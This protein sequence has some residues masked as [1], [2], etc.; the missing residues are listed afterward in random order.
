MSPL[1]RLRIETVRT[2]R[3]R[4]D[5]YRVRREIYRSDPAAVIP[6]RKMEWSFLN[7]SV[8]PFY[9]HARREVFLAYEGNRP[10]GRIAAIVDDLHNQHYADRLGFF[11]FFECPPDQEVADRLLNAA[12][13]YLVSQGRDQVRGPMNPSMKGEFGVLVEGHQHPPRVMMAHTTN[14]YAQL[15]ETFGF[16][17]V[18]RFHAYSLDVANDPDWGNKV[19]RMRALSDRICARFPDLKVEPATKANVE[20]RLYEINTIGNHIRSVGWGFVPLTSEE[21]TYMVNQLRRVI[22][23]RAVVTAHYKNELVGYV[24]TVPD[25]N[26]AIK[27]TKGPYDW[28]R[29]AQMPRLLKKIRQCR[30]IAI[31]VH[32]DFRRKGINTVLTKKMFDITNDYDHWEFGWIAED[33]T[34]S[35]GALSSAVPLDRY[36]VYHVYQRAL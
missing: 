27:R 30:L 14:Y 33:N 18:K 20:Q 32:P 2:A 11:G 4:S 23:P 17:T 9:L 29:F 13:D 1:N 15:L 10:V 19:A 24:V 8:H 7:P 26:W 12:A 28:L 3:Q 21:L 22:D 6:F 5:F 34:A 36:R 16:E 31:G 25:V 35:I